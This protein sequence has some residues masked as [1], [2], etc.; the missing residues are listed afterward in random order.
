MLQF[1][2]FIIIP[3]GILLLG[4]L[5]LFSKKWSIFPK[6]MLFILSGLILIIGYQLTPRIIGLINEKKKIKQSVLITSDTKIWRPKY[7]F[8]PPL[9]WMNDPCDLYFKDSIYHLSFI[10]IPP[11]DSID[12]SSPQNSYFSMLSNIDRKR[13]GKAVT[14][15]LFDWQYK[16]DLIQPS[17]DPKS[18]E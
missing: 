12:F 1:Y 2:K 3:I 18:C 8:S 17:T 7:H 5:W 11:L 13:W 4:N 16:G 14:T 15:N 9:G 6:S 10:H